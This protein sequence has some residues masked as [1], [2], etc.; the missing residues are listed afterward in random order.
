MSSAYEILRSEILSGKIAPGTRLQVRELSEHFKFGLTPTREALMRLAKDGL[1]QS[2][3][4]KGAHVT[5]VSIAELKDLTQARQCVESWCLRR[6]MELGDA[7][8]E[9]DI[10]HALHVLLKTDVLASPDDKGPSYKWEE[11]HR[12]FHHALVSACGSPWQL[13]FWETLS[14][15][16]ERYRNMRLMNLDTRDSDLQGA[17]EQHKLIAQTV[18]D[19]DINKA[20]ELASNHIAETE[21]SVTQFL[22]ER[23]AK[24]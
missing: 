22:I 23:E 9:A 20:I 15:N 19:R 7:Q 16:L 14:D 17:N 8:W 24:T 5:P 18:I 10:L 2:Q 6:A 12:K 4:N 3:A 21:V 13:R 1:V 11:R